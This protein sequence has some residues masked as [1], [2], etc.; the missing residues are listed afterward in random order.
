MAIRRGALIGRTAFGLGVTALGAFVAAETAGL[1]VAPGYARIGPKL[2]P[3]IVAA[4]LVLT[5]L[6]LLVQAVRQGLGHD[7]RHVPP[8][9]FGAL[10]GKALS[11]VMAGL[12]AQMALLDLLGFWLSAAL[13]FAVVAHAFGNRNIAVNLGIGLA[14]GLA[15]Q[16]IFTRGL[17]LTLPAGVLEGIL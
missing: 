11:L 16:V 15:A 12:L 10:D 8:L 5:G 1:P 13:L 14:L 6:V 3:Y 17:G 9:A 7:R 2:F 4:G